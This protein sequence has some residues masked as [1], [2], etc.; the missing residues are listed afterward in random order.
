MA[1]CPFF[2]GGWRWHKKGNTRG[3]WVEHLT[4]AQ[5]TISCFVGS[6]PMAGSVLTAQSL[7]PASDSVSLSTLPPRV[8][9]L[10]LFLSLPLSKINKEKRRAI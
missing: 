10:S 2:Q 3:T 6:S 5:V 7:E 8:L 9:C 4:L 1:W